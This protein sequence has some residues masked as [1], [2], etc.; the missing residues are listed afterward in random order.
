[1]LFARFL[2]ENIVGVL[3]QPVVI[4]DGTMTAIQANRPFYDTYALR[5]DEV[6][7]QPFFSISNGFWDI[8]ALRIALEKV[9]PNDT[10]IENLVIEQNFPG[11]GRRIVRVSARMIFSDVP[12]EG[13][14]FVVM[15]DITGKAG[16]EKK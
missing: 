14:V 8:P 1:M 2:A 6:K 10:R 3:S 7:N 16:A 5:E 12:S 13:L 9:L 15:E 4:L 11:I